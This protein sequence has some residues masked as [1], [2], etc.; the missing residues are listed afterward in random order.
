MRV[1]QQ[2]G[3]CAGAVG[4]GVVWARER[5]ADAEP[6]DTRSVVELVVG[7]GHD[8]HGAT[9]PQRL[10]GGAHATLMNDDG[11]VRE[12][13]GVGEI[14]PREDRGRKVGWGE[15]FSEQE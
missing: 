10:R 7:E 15:I 2:R 6:D 1:A 8:E 4:S 14:V 11:G 12:N 5:A 13:L 9:G 3:E